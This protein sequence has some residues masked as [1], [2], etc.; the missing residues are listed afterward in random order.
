MNG[1]WQAERPTVVP[2]SAVLDR[3]KAR[4]I[5]QYRR[6]RTGQPYLVFSGNVVAEAS[7]RIRHGQEHDRWT[8][9][10]V[11]RTDTGDYAVGRVMRTLWQQ[12]DAVWYKVEVCPTHTRGIVLVGCEAA[13]L[14]GEVEKNLLRRLA[15]AGAALCRVGRGTAWLLRLA[16]AVLYP[17]VS[18]CLFAVS[19]LARG[20]ALN[21]VVRN[22]CI[23]LSLVVLFT[24][25]LMVYRR[26]DAGH[27]PPSE[28]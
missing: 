5:P 16:R 28:S 11:Y 12:A 21:V 13:P 27:H 4:G 22:Y 7:D 23:L 8:D 18:A 25:S 2:S 26:Y 1:R 17:C 24:S 14:P 19:A 15:R 10:R 3:R 9:I 20:S 6:R